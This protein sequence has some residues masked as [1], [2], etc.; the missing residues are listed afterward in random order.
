V[1]YLSTY[2]DIAQVDK[3]PSFEAGPDSQIHVFDGGPVVPASCF[4]QCSNAP[5]AG[6]PWSMKQLELLD[7]VDKMPIL[8]KVGVAC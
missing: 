4:I 6:G 2:L 8:D 1:H 7:A 3:L 5:H